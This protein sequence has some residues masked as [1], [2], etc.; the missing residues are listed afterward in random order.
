MVDTGRRADEPVLGLGDHER[1]ALADDALR[2][3]Q[4]HLDLARIALARSDPDGCLGRLDPVEMDDAP[5][6]LRH[7]L[8]REH[9]YVAVLQRRVL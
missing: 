5:F 7:A 3:A 1:P 8:L 9:Q 4:D 6:G 2:L